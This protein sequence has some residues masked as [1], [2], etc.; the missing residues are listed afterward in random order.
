MVFSFHREEN[1]DNLINLK[2]I[3]DTVNYLVNKKG[4]QHI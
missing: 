4:C 3:L 2:K 1:I